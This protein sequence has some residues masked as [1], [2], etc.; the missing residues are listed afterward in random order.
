MQ[1][2]NEDY[3]DIDMQKDSLNEPLEAEA[4][5]LESGN[6]EKIAQRIVG[7]IEMRKKTT[8]IV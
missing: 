8:R 3:Q 5:F 1:T 7:T 2:E 4:D 6:L